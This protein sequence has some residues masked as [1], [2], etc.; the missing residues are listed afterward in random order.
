[1]KVRANEI[2]LLRFIAAVAV[3]LF[4]FCFRGYAASG[5]TIMPYPLLAPYAKYGY[6]GVELFFMISGFVILMTAS[7]GNIR[8]FVASRIA[9]LYPAYWVCCTVTFIAGLALAYQPATIFQYVSNLTMLNGFVGIR[10]IDGSYWSLAVEMKFYVLVG[11]LLAC[12]QIRNAENWVLA[13]LAITLGLSVVPLAFLTDFLFVGYAPYFIAGASLFLVWSEGMTIRRAAVIFASWLLALHHAVVESE[14]RQVIFH[15][16]F[17]PV[18][19]VST[20]TA[21]F[22]VLLMVALRRT[23]PLGRRNWMTLG[24][25]TY[26]LYLIHHNLGF[27]LFNLAYPRLNAHVVLWGTVA[28]MLGVAYSVNVF[29]ERRYSATLKAAVVRVLNR[30]AGLGR[31][32]IEGLATKGP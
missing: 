7:S 16:F 25:L 4:H 29:V 14:Q 18:V 12:G 22:I 24:A 2:D 5:L 10:Y 31:E 15:Q 1:M 26:P 3:V 20:I 8:Q 21:F 23:G 6:L 27:S 30:G 11:V 9:R 32:D 13:W 17:S 19:V 28:F